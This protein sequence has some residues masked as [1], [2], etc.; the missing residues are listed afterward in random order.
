MAQKE[1]VRYDFGKDFSVEIAMVVGE[2]YRYKDEWKF[3]VVGSDPKVDLR[4]S[5]KIMV[6]MSN[7]KFS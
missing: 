2:I 1:L 4:L 6:S 5:V 7:K 3:N